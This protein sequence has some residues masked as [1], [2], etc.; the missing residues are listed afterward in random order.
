MELTGQTS[1]LIE[2]NLMVSPTNLEPGKC[3][4]PLGYSL[5]LTAPGTATEATEWS[6]I[7][8]DILF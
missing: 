8:T 7:K 5:V 3:L 1:F 2:F 4:T 6:K